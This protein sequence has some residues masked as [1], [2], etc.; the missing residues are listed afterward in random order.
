M[1]FEGEEVSSLR[2]YVEYECTLSEIAEVQTADTECQPY[3]LIESSLFPT[4]F[5]LRPL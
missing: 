4:Y 5:Q 2:P 1:K 3:M